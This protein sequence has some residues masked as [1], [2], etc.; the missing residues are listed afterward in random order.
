[1]RP[2]CMYVCMYV[3]MYTCLL[4]ISVLLVVVEDLV[5]IRRCGLYT[6]L[7]REEGC[8]TSCSGGH[9]G[10]GKFVDD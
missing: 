4:R 8:A 2:I 9:G 5:I 10:H 7:L 3:C 6:C 1:M